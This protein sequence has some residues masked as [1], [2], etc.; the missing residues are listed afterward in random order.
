METELLALLQKPLTNKRSSQLD[1][2]L[3]INSHLRNLPKADASELL[4]NSAKRIKH[5]VDWAQSHGVV[6]LGDS[7]E[8]RES[9]GKGLGL[10]ATRLINASLH[11]RIYTYNQSS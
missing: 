1:L 4:P 7:V 3:A 10:F 2:V 5:F 11:I 6:G 8:I 9:T